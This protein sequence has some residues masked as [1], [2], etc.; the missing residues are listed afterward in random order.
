MHEHQDVGFVANTVLPNVNFGPFLSPED[1]AGGG[2][3]A[4]WVADLYKQELLTYK[5]DSVPREYAL[6]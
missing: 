3:T 1:Q 5:R 2:S 6:N 4:T